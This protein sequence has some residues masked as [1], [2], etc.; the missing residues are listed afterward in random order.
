[1]KFLLLLL[2]FTVALSN[3]LLANG[4]LTSDG[5]AT[6]TRLQAEGGLFVVDFAAQDKSNPDNCAQ[7][8]VAIV[9]D[10]TVNGDRLVSLLMAAHMA[11]KNIKLYATGC[12]SA[13]G[14]TYPKIHA[15]LVY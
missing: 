2:L 11:E 10:Q 4:W 3:A 9:D 14:S 12:V 15:V 8:N 5:S 6:I 7:S 13:W 1:M